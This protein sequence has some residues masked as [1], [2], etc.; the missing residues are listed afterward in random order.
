MVGRLV[1]GVLP[2]L[3]REGVVISGGDYENRT[4]FIVQ[5]SFE[6]PLVGIASAQLDRTMPPQYEAMCQALKARVE[7]KQVEGVH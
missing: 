3:G 5:E 6:G 1:V 4:R 2:E 7:G